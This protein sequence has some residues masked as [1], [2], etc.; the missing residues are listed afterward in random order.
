MLSLFSE[1][2]LIIC[3]FVKRFCQLKIF[4]KGVITEIAVQ[5]PPRLLVFDKY[6]F[7]GVEKHCPP[8]KGS[9][10]NGV[11]TVREGI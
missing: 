8:P 2:L 10:K 11:F 9:R 1:I 5:R 6:A 3:N 4:L 7:S